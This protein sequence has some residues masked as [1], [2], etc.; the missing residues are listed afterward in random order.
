M[1]NEAKQAIED[2]VNGAMSGNWLPE[3][4]YEMKT[5]PEV[6]AEIPIA[7]FVFWVECK[8]RLLEDREEAMR[9]GNSAAIGEAESAIILF[10]REAA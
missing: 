10:D 1:T 8:V 9:Q 7:T 4:F 5:S 3:E 2:A 6:R